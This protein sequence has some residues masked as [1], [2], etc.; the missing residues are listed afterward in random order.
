MTAYSQQAPGKK[1]T[2][3]RPSYAL[4]IGIDNYKK[5]NWSP[6]THAI[7]KASRVGNELEKMGFAVTYRMN[8]NLIELEFEIKKFFV[9]EKIN[10]NSSLF[11]WFSGHGH[12]VG[13]QGFLVPADA[14][15]KDDRGFKMKAFP[16]GRLEGYLRVTKAK[17]VFLVFDAC[18]HGTIFRDEGSDS[19]VKKD[20]PMF[21]Y[22]VHRYLYCLFNGKNEKYDGAFGEMFIKTL[23]NENKAD[24][25]GDNYLTA[26]EIKEK[27]K[28]FSKKEKVQL[29]FGKLKGF[30]QGD[31]VFSLPGQPP[32]E[33]KGDPLKGG[34]EGP[35][36][37]KIPGGSFMM[38]DLQGNGFRD[39]KPGHLVS[40][41][42]I[43][44]SCFEITVNEYELFRKKNNI[45][46]TGDKI[47]GK[48]PVT[49]VS[50]LDAV[51]YTKWLTEQTGFT[52]RLP[53]EAEWEYFARANT[54]TDYWWGNEIGQEKACCDGCG[55][56]WGWDKKEKI[57]PVGSFAPNSFGI[58][59]TVG[60]VWEWTCSEYTPGYNESKKEENCLENIKTGG[61]LVVLRGGA[62]NEKPRHCRVS[63]RKSLNPGERSPYIGFRVVRELKKGE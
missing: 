50:L 10:E 28:D 12:N 29:K 34:G 36:M 7:S 17:H 14:P 35:Q 2:L 55:A 57:A 9:D 8:L 6:L 32:P 15:K 45:K 33:Y 60:N 43:A 16:V 3:S 38:G 47:S 53:K 18:F 1:D 21:K 11:L 63:R 54:N 19:P 40:V 46:P 23:R 24:D 58:Y 27:M 4:V 41:S 51:A 49:N 22:P 44:V 25:N 62:W 26:G 39:E 5:K 30:D 37:T 56:R 59:D 42:P 13:K 61:E 52:Y 20:D 31:F 48:R